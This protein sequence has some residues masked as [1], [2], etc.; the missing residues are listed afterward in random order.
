[1]A[2]DCADRLATEVSEEREKLEVE[3]RDWQEC[4]GIFTD[5]AF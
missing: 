1:L 2:L 4:M 3:I 5:R